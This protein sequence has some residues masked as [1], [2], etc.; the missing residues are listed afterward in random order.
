MVAHFR[1]EHGLPDGRFRRHHFTEAMFLR[2][3]DVLVPERYFTPPCPDPGAEADVV[4]PLTCI[5]ARARTHA[6]THTLARTLAHIPTWTQGRVSNGRTHART[7]ARGTLARTLARIPPWA[8]PQ[9]KAYASSQGQV[10]GVQHQKILI[11][12]FSPAG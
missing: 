11:R 8:Q 5:A 12:R 2:R 7:H 6:G 1:D 9:S 4:E 10:K 3:V